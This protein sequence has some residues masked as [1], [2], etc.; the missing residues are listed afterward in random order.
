MDKTPEPGE[1][2]LRKLAVN[3]PLLFNALN[4]YY[5]GV[6]SYVQAIA[7]VAAMMSKDRASLLEMLTRQ[8]NMSLPAALAN[9][10]GIKLPV[11]N[12][13]ITTSRTVAKEHAV[14]YYSWKNNLKSGMI[15]LYNNDHDKLLE[16]M[17]CLKKED[18]SI[19]FGKIRT[20]RQVTEL[21]V[22]VGEWK[23]DEQSTKT[24]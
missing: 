2:E 24:P 3:D 19:E 18:P 7:T 4:A 8:M 22:F 13:W 23:S 16:R 9:P 6:F 21:Q 1:A 17:A 10:T 11:E 20:E 5:A 15:T 12:G 14:D